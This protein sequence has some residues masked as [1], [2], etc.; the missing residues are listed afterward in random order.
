MSYMIDNEVSVIIMNHKMKDFWT[1]GEKLKYQVV[2][3]SY[4]TKKKTCAKKKV[5][6]G[7]A[8]II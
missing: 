2:Y 6:Y 4:V 5:Y 7:Y 1:L 3:H 8:L